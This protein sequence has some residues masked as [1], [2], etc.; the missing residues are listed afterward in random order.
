MLIHLQICAWHLVNITWYVFSYSPLGVE[1]LISLFSVRAEH[2]CKT[3]QSA[4]KNVQLD[5]GIT[6]VLRT[7]RL[8][9]SYVLHS[10]SYFHACSVSFIIFIFDFTVVF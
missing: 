9:H 4:T 8:V 1:C 5:A 7:A 6:L 2:A 10:P 3:N